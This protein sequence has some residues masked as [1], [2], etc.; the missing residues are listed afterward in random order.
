MSIRA[1]RS[2]RKRRI[3][4]LR[5]E[6]ARTSGRARGFHKSKQSTF[7]RLTGAKDAWPSERL[8]AT[9]SLYQAASVRF[10]FAHGKDGHCQRTKR[11]ADEQHCDGQPYIKR[12][13]TFCAHAIILECA[14]TDRNGLSVANE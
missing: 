5:G 6:A 7:A 1:I 4:K 8:E 9:G 11:A 13:G 10:T 12:T 3:Q 2:P 14:Q